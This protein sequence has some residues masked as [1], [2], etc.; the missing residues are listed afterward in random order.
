MNDLV[1]KDIRVS[2]GSK[3]V[4]S[5]FCLRIN[6]GELVVILGP[7]GCGKSTLLSVISGLK[8]PDSGRILFG[9]S[10]LFSKH[11]LINIP[12]EERNIGFVFQSYA[13]WPHM[14][15]AQNIAF[16]LRVRKYSSDRIRH[17]VSEILDIVHMRGYEQKYPNQLSGGEKQ[18]IALARSLVYHPSLLLLDEPLANLDANLKTSLIHEI[19]DIQQKLGITMLYVTHDQNEA[20]E[21][22]DRIVIIN[23]GKIMQQGNP[24]DIY[25]HCENL[26]VADFIGKNNILSTCSQKKVC[27]SKDVKLCHSDYAI[28]IRPENIEII[29]SGIYQGTVKEILYKGDHTEYIIKSNGTDLL[30]STNNDAKLEKGWDIAF[31]IKKYEII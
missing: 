3:L 16:P 2:Y 12:A 21:I 8:K 1:I 23:E 4:L 5:D 15:V 24:R 30:A 28:T 31:N 25:S 27:F 9:N 6:G 22:A 14:N 18:R 20:F 7:S 17:S 13:L 29:P 26:F 11:D 10:C 19:K